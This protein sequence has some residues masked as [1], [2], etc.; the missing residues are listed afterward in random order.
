VHCVDVYFCEEGCWG[1]DGRG[2]EEILSLLKLAIMACSNKP[3]NV[4]FH[5]GPPEAKGNERFRSEYHLVA[6]IV[7]GCVNDFKTGCWCWDD[8]VGSMRILLPKFS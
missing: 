5:I 6:N 4:G 8:L 1:C 2:N 7:V 3:S